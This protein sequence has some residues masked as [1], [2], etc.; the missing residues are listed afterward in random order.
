[1]GGSAAGSIGTGGSTSMYPCE[2]LPCGSLCPLY[3]PGMG[4]APQADGGEDG[5]GDELVAAG[6]CAP[7][8][9]CGPAFPVCPGTMCM[10]VNDC[11][12]IASVCEVCADG[13]YSC[14]T[15][16][17]VDGQCVV[18]AP[19]CNDECSTDTDCGVTDLL[20]PCQICPDGT[21]SCP[22]RQC[23]MGRCVG[24]VPGC[25]GYDPCD[26]LEC[27]DQCS[28]CPPDD[29]ACAA[30]AVLTFCN[31]TGQCQTGVPSCGG[32]ECMSAMDCPLTDVCLMCADGTCGGVDCVNGRCTHSCPNDPAECKQTE[33]CG[34]A[35]AICQ[36]CADGT[37]A[38][39]ACVGG[40]CEMTCPS[41]QTCEN[42]DMC[43]SCGSCGNLTVCVPYQCVE[44]RCVLECGG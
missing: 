33:D 41:M 2:G 12:A 44:K 37:C 25:G 1:M 23:V 17:C 8:G 4:M 40:K 18:D 26:G 9:S 13:S 19:G 34:E 42:D 14:P 35:P 32:G 3:G 21:S 30:P 43:P 7:D 16:A 20:A 36:L 15:Q 31:A 29:M 27:G 5:S 22:T 28:A 10:T 24:S 11:P 38:G 6:Y 39:M